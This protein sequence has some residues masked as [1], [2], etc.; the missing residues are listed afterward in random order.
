M[1]TISNGI[2]TLSLPDGLLRT[3]E[4]GWSPVAHAQSR[5]LGGSIWIDVSV[6]VSGEPIT[7]EGGSSGDTVWGVMTRAEFAALRTFADV[8]GAE[9]TLTYRS[10]A[11]RV[12]WRHSDPPALAASDVIPYSNPSAID[13]VI[14]VL[15]FLRI[16]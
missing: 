10:V 3:D 5:T 15:K 4:H 1:N 12:I 11:M 7:L 13:Y 8:P 2:E 16:D 6:A 9:Y 14:P